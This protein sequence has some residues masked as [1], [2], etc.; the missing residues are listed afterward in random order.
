MKIAVFH[1]LPFGGAKD[2]TLNLSKAIKNT[3]NVVDL[4]YVSDKKEEDDL[5]RLDNVYFYKFNEKKWI[6]KN[7]RIRLY[8]DTVELFKLY[9]LH[10]RIAREIDF[11]KYDVV[12]VNGS[13][14]IEAPFLLRFLTSYKIFYCHDPN[15]R[16]VYENA[17]SVSK[18]VGFIKYNYEKLNRIIRKKLDKSN[19]LKADL[20]LAN[21]KYA[22]KIIRKTYDKNSE[23]LYL[24]VDT[25]F[26]KQKNVKKDIDV[27]YIGS[28]N[29]LD[30]YDTLKK[31]YKFLPK[32]LIIKKVMFEDGWISDK[33][34]IR[35][36]YQRSK[37]VVCLA[38]NEPF[39]LVPLEAMSCGV[40]VIAVDEGGYLDTV[41]DNETGFLIKRDPKTLYFAISK[42]LGDENLR[43]RMG[44]RAREYAKKR[45]TWDKSAKNFMKILKTY[46]L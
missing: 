34:D 10:K 19:F 27:L 31:S 17:L 21:S 18:N 32:N 12:L 16:I 11:K 25:D 26:F 1:E 15:Y 40:S 29:I 45:W 3:S 7:W 41:V 23:V 28:Y 14:Y 22:K 24:G 33:K 44:D 35:D 42:L 4:Y 5:R 2:A 20:I 30:G 46:N 6:G 13:K 39:G 37:I 8:K 43:L 38:R 9:R 36:L